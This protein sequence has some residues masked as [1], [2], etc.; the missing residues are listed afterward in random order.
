[1]LKR[2]SN[3]KGSTMVLLVVAIAVISLLGTSILGVTMMNYKIKKTNSDLKYSFYMS[4]TGLDIAYAEAYAV[5]LQA[6]ED[7]N[8][9]AQKEF[10]RHNEKYRV[11][12]S[13]APELNSNIIEDSDGDVFYEYIQEE[14]KR[15]AKAEFEG[16]YVNAVKD[17]IIDSLNGVNSDGILLS[18]SEKLLKLDID[19]D[20]SFNNFSFNNYSCTCDSDVCNNMY[21]KINGL[22]INNEIITYDIPIV[23]LP[24]CK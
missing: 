3:N 24:D 9:A 21:I 2:I 18:N 11:E 4:E 17:N 20:E 16:E 12:L 22:T 5:I 19:T 10:E 7:A 1:M 6:V 23:V 8:D 15:W 14:I 13:M